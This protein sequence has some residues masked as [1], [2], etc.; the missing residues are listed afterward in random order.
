MTLDAEPET[1]GPFSTF[2]QGAGIRLLP[3]LLGALAR[4]RSATMAGR[5][6]ATMVEPIAHQSAGTY[7]LLGLPKAGFTEDLLAAF[8]GDPRFALRGFGR[9]FVKAPYPAF[10]PPW[11]DDNNYKSAP[12]SLD[13]AKLELRKFWA[14][15]WRPVQRV[16]R[17]QAVLTGNFAYHAEQEFAAAVQASGTPVIAMHK[18]AL[19]TPGLDG[20]FRYLYETRRQPFPGARVCVYNN[21]ERDIQLYAGI[22]PESRIT[23][24][25]MPR[26]D[27]I[28]HWRVAA[29]ARQQEQPARPRVLFFSFHPKTGLPSLP[30]KPGAPEGRLEHLGEGLD[31]LSWSRLV[32][33]SHRAVTRLAMD[34]PD[35][36]VVVKGKG[37]LL[38]WLKLTGAEGALRPGPNLRV[39]V[40]GDPQDLIM[41]ATVICGFTTTALLEAMAAGKRVIVPRFFEAVEERTAPYF[42]DL[43]GAV[44]HADSED[45]LYARLQHGVRNPQPVTA[46]LPAE[47]A[48]LLTHWA[49]NPD[50]KS[51]AR[52]A[53]AVLAEL[54]ARR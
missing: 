17:A 25:G 44:D 13:A 29:A 35:I 5:V 11:V 33:A 14:D 15:A 10:L 53:A 23:V 50:G 40:G 2:R 54:E 7:R 38:K 28:H 12:A 31:E 27:R 26:L 42:L 36:D 41:G 22:V 51:G 8:G 3:P 47:R 46:E 24:S 21:I 30:R 52:V 4:R 1:R 19:K 43:A 37:D 18:E 34:N 48:R 9:D 32:A 6:M 39:M 16:A 49:G 45:D 20:F